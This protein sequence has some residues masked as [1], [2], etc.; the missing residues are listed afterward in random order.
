MVIWSEF[1]MEQYRGDDHR[2]NAP[3]F[4]KYIIKYEI[5]LLKQAFSN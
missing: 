1:R 4:N 5:N 2:E 3:H